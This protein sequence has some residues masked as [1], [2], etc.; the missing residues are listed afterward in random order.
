MKYS[1]YGKKRFFITAGMILMLALL[2]LFIP[3]KADENTYKWKTPVDGSYTGLAQE[4]DGTWFYVKNGRIDWG[5]CGLINYWGT[6]FYVNDGYID[7]SYCNLVQNYGMWFYVD[8]GKI[9][10]TTDTLAQVNGQG[11][12]YKVTDSMIDWGFKGLTQYGEN[13]FYLENGQINWGYNGLCPNYGMWFYVSGGWIDWSYS[14]PAYYQGSLF[15]VNN[16]LLDWGFSKNIEYWGYTYEVKNGRIVK[17]WVPYYGTFYYSLDGKAATETHDIG[18]RLE[19]FTTD[20]RYINTWGM[21]QAA[22]Y[23][24][25]YTQYLIL[26]SLSDRVTKIYQRNGNSWVPVQAY[27]CTVGNTSRG[28]GTVK[29]D[30]Y[31]GYSSWNNPV[32]RGFSFE[33][34]EGHT[35]YFWTRFCDSFLFHSILYDRD[36]YNESVYGNALGEEL[37]HGCVRMRAENARWIYEN[38]PDGTRVLVY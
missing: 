11:Q 20:G 7:W 24:N 22:A 5:F 34:S 12:W 28:W 31:I 30:F 36:T 8:H 27:L 3:A 21:D 23:Y 37:S 13:W 17:G 29:G 10:W 25:S 35:L 14:G 4:E 15:H 2:V 9:S 16:A 38:I 33:D 32:K 6:W 26:V 1:T 18:G 19:V